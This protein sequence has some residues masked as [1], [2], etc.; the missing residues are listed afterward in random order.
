[1]THSTLRALALFFVLCGVLVVG[2]VYT[3]A[4]TV[5]CFNGRCHK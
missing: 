2:L 5:V 1:M 3:P 4:S